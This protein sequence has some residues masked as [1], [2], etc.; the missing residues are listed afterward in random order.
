MQH[1]SRDVAHRDELSLEHIVRLPEHRRAKPAQRI[2]PRKRTTSLH[3]RYVPEVDAP[4]S[5]KTPDEHCLLPAMVPTETMDAG[6]FYTVE[7][8]CFSLKNNADGLMTSARGP[9]DSRE[10][11]N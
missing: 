6:R 3:Y 5:F 7:S 4:T 9:R 8:S 2:I 11:G 1:R 10:T